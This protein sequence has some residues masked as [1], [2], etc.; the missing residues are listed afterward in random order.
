MGDLLVRCGGVSVML[1]WSAEAVFAERGGVPHHCARCRA[2]AARVLG[3]GGLDRVGA[4]WWFAT[5]WTGLDGL[6]R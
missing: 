1:F 3:N 6:R 5:W 4:G 2:S